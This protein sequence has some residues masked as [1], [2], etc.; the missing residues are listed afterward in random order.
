MKYEMF[1]V[2]GI[3]VPV[4]FPN[5]VQHNQVVAHTSCGEK[6]TPVSA[7]SIILLGPHFPPRVEAHGESI[8]LNLKARPEDS[9]ILTKYFKSF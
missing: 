8:G 7:G 6:G 4:I 9:G 3:D 2:D 5:V 1:D